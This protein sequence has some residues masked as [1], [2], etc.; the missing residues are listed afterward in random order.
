MEIT[1][2]KSANSMPA[3]ASTQPAAGQVAEAVL[4]RSSSG[5]GDLPESQRVSQNRNPEQARFDAVQQAMENLKTLKLPIDPHSIT[6]FKATDG[7]YVTRY[8]DLETG[9]VVYYPEQVL[10]ERNSMYTGQPLHL[11]ETQV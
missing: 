8:R 6:I 1:A 2:I 11:Y 7:Q 5:R 3:G 4:P 10:L 9:E